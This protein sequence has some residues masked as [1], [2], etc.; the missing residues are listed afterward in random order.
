ML[1]SALST[2]NMMI[3]FGLSQPE[4]QAG[5]PIAYTY[6]KKKIIN[7]LSDFHVDFCEKRHIFPYRI[8]EYRQYTYK[9]KFPWKVMPEPLF[10]ACEKLLGWHYLIKAHPL[11]DS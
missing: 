1:Y 5:C 11:T 7:L 4:A 6:T 8:K 10:H 2:K 9:K 3:F